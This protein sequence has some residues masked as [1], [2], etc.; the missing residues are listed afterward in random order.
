MPKKKNPCA[1]SRPKDKPYEVWKSLDE[2]WQWHVLKKWQVDDD[3]PYARWFCLVKSPYMPE[4]EL[5]DVYVK[6]IKAHATL[7]Q[8]NY[9]TEASDAE[10]TQKT[11]QEP[12]TES[13]G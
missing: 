7:I 12:G 13:A 2:K 8:S 11:E 4:G 3:K 5:G 1:K 6:E 10:Q 9:D